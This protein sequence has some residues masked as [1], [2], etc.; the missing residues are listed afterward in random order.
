MRILM[1][2]NYTHESKSS[3]RSKVSVRKGS[4]KK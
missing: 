2:Y 3:E 1:H 4:K